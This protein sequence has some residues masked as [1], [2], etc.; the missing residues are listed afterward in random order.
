MYA[1]VAR[2]PWGPWS[3]AAPI[4]TNEQAAEDLVCG[5]QAPAGCLAQPDP[6][7]RPQCIEAVDPLAG[8]NLYGAS[9]IEQLTREAEGDGGRPAADVFWLYSTWH[10]YSVVLAR[11]RVAV[12]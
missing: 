3:D 5:H 11:T 7:I 1:R 8:G 2:D 4:L 10:P 6:L 12:E 9:V